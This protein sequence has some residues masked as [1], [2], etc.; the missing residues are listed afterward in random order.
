MK[1]HQGKFRMDI[2]KK[3]ST[4]RVTSHWNR[5]PRGVIMAPSLSE[6]KD[7]VDVAGSRFRQF[8]EEQ[9]IGLNDPLSPFHLEI[10]CNSC[11]NSMYFDVSSTSSPTQARGDFPRTCWSGH[12][13]FC[14]GQL[15]QSLFNHESDLWNQ[16]EG[17]ASRGCYLWR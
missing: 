9:G 7:H 17:S 8:C 14:V 10:F 2:W 3:F 1:V 16:R 13:T 5:H 4:V 12:S 11:N 6:F 15:I